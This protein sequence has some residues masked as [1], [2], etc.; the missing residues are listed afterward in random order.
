MEIDK[1]DFDIDNY[2]LENLNSFFGITNEDVSK[3]DLLEVKKKYDSLVFSSKSNEEQKKQMLNFIQQGIEKIIYSIRRTTN[4]GEPDSVNILK[5]NQLQYNPTQKTKNL[6]DLLTQDILFSENSSHMVVTP[7]P[8][9]FIYTSPGESFGG[10]INPLEKRII[11]KQICFD[12]LQR[13][14]Y[15]NTDSASVMFHL[16]E[17]LKNV[18]SM[19]LVTIELPRMWHTYSKEH[20]NVKMTINMYELKTI[21][22]VSI[23]I[24]LPEGNYNT[25]DFAS[26]ITNIFK[27]NEYLSILI[28]YV[29]LVNGQTVITMD[30]T[31]ENNP[32]NPSSS[33]FSPLFHYEVIF[34][35]DDQDLR[36]TLGWSIG[37]RKAHYIVYPNPAVT[38]YTYSS[39]SATVFYGFLQSE[40]TFGSNLEHYLY[41]EVD[42]FNNNY[43]TNTIVSQSFKS[44]IGQ[45]ILGRITLHTVPYTIV[46]NGKSDLIHRTREYFGPVSITKLKIRLLNKFGFPVNLLQNDYSF[47]LEFKQLYTP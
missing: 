9:P 5:R 36:S 10:V 19:Q 44:F 14:N 16:K 3:S 31:V 4:V 7:Q 32:A 33:S 18:T 6:G 17:P 40:S 11:T 21:S 24:E 34:V 13:D 30:P 2:T 26:T 42:D 27:N 39:T 35:S 28:C 25:D 23:P 8:V 43:S 41:F 45:C 47:V 12:T 29:D 46:E 15:S 20:E 37:F 38:N 22:F 1:I